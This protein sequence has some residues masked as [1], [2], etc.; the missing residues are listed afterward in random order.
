MC[1]KKFQTHGFTLIEL[2]VVIAIIGMLVALLLPAVQAARGG[3][4]RSAAAIS[5][6][7]R[8]RHTTSSTQKVLPLQ[9]SAGG[10]DFAAPHR[11]NDHIASFFRRGQHL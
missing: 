7:W 8:W 4:A 10:A 2:L 3:D 1:K 11:G 5:G 6:N 9:Y